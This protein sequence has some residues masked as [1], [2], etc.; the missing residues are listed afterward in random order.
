MSDTPDAADAIP[1]DAVENTA[2][3]EPLGEPGKAALEAERRARKE[4]E[5][6][7]REARDQL[8]ALRAEQARERVARAKGLTDAQAR[9]LSGS[10]VDELEARPTGSWPRSSPTRPRNADRRNG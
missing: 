3:G 1:A 2:D 6:Q 7:A 10:D 9:Y 4:A 8:T 5:R